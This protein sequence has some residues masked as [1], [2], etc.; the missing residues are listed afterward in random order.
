[1]GTEMIEPTDLKIT[2]VGL[3]IQE[4]VTEDKL[5][6]L[7]KDEKSKK[8]PEYIRTFSKYSTIIRD[9]TSIQQL[10]FQCG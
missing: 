4:S 6:E 8:S 3:H 5:I 2:Q 1:M 10:F 7:F 9:N